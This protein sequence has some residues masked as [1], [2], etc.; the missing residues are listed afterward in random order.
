MTRRRNFRRI[1]TEVGEDAG[2]IT[3]EVKATEA[4]PT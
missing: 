4:I 2:Q 1:R 3:V